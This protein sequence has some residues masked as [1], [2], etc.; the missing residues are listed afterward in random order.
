MR[1]LLAYAGK[2]PAVCEPIDVSTVVAEMVELLKVSISK[3]ATLKIELP[4]NLPAVRANAAQMRQVVLNLVTNASEALGSETGVITVRTSVSRARLEQLTGLGPGAVAGDWILLEVGDTGCGMTDDVVAR[5]YDPFFTMKFAGRGLGLAVVQGIVRGHGGAIDV[6]SAP[7]QGT[8]FRILLPSTTHAAASPETIKE[9]APR[10]ET[11]TAAGTIFFVE[12]EASLQVPVSSVLRRNGYRVIEA[13]DGV[14]AVELFRVNQSRI[15]VVLLDMTLPG[16][17]GPEVYS[18]L[19]EIQP[20]VKVIFTTAYSQQAALNEMVGREGWG[21]IR[22]PY[23]LSDLLNL[24]QRVLQ[25]NKSYRRH[26]GTLNRCTKVIDP[27]RESRAWGFGRRSVVSQV[28]GVEHR[29]V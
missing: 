17:S 6:T 4:R 22:K 11:T 21:F 15:D 29:R 12:D 3:R 28:D 9:P 13:S 19:Q 18:Q 16:K 25:G 8:T 20:D 24:L 2:E 23:Q 1:E 5:I 7:G 26:P 14:T 27:N 10:G